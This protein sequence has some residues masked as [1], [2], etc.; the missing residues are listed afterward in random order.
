MAPRLIARSIRFPSQ[1][2]SAG[3]RE[4]GGDRGDLARITETGRASKPVRM[5]LP[6]FKG[7]GCRAPSRSTRPTPSW[8]PTARRAV[9]S[10]GEST[11]LIRQR[12]LVRV[13][14]RPPLP[15][16]GVAGDVAQL[17]EHLLCKERVRS[18][19][20]LVST[21]SAAPARP[22]T[23]PLI[24][25]L[26]IL[27]AIDQRT[28]GDPDALRTR[29]PSRGRTLPTGYVKSVEREVVDLRFRRVV[30]GTIPI[31]ERRRPLGQR[32]E[33]VKLHRARGG[34]LGAKSR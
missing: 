14:K 3:A 23:G 19:S 33:G 32:L 26:E 17:A 12:S 1:V 16:T 10:A 15:L 9:S 30:V 5:F 18:S 28:A 8:L 22:R 20:L 2:G 24:R 27:E 4:G 13:Q 31:P 6:L 34:C 11:A 7:Q 29:G 21:T 25:V